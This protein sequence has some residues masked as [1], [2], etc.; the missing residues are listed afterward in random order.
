VVNDAKG[1][2]DHLVNLAKAMQ[3]ARV[4]STNAQP[5]TVGSSPRWNVHRGIESNWW[6][7]TRYKGCNRDQDRRMDAG[8]GSASSGA[9]RALGARGLILERRIVR[10]RASQ[11][12]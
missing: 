6:R 3:R 9:L 7:E 12:N 11:R 8:N 4:T 10:S 2:E 5:R 1:V